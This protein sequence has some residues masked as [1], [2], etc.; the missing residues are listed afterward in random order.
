MG[1][2]PG[3]DSKS[4]QLTSTTIQTDPRQRSFGPVLTPW[5]VRSPEVPDTLSLE[6]PADHGGA[7]AEAF[8][9]KRLAAAIGLAK[10]FS[11]DR[12]SPG[13]SMISSKNCRGAVKSVL[14]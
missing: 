9:E 2:G 3:F 5:L 6:C 8:F 14:L 13:T 10:L 11:K 12:F 4:E 1:L 7:R